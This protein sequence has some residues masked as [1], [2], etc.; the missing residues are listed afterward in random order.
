MK[1]RW[2]VVARDVNDDKVMD[3]SRHVFR[4]FAEQECAKRQAAI[5]VPLP[6]RPLYSLTVERVR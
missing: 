3:W 2:A 1:H 6:G 4:R 5:P